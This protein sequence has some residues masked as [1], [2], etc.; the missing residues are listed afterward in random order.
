MADAAGDHVDEVARA[1]ET[2]REQVGA[3]T[4]ELVV[5]LGSGLSEATRPAET[6]V[7][8]PYSQIP[9]LAIPTAAGHPGKLLAGWWG[10]RRVLLFQGRSHFYE[11]H[12]WLRVTMPVRIAAA[13]GAGVC[14]FTNM[15]G[16]IN[17]R[18]TPGSMVVIDD[19]L[20]FMGSNPLVGMTSADPTEMFPD[21]QE[22]YSRRLNALLDRASAMTGVAVSHGVYVA[23]SGPNYETPAEVRALGLLGADV[24]GM[25]TVG[26]VLVARRSGVECCAISCVANLAAGVLGDGA[27]REPITHADVLATASE[28]QSRLAR[29]LDAFV[30]LL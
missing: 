15:S 23:V 18:L 26:E 16:A 24:V 19:H 30:G 2:I 10:K 7:T 13:M 17:P 21:M 20:N 27:G 6:L 4:P 5:M 11:G 14:V 8:I 12:S 9:G 28:T 29:L 1:V 22:A 25:S 3:F